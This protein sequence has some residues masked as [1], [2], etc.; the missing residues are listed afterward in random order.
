MRQIME[1]T[2]RSRGEVL[3]ME[4]NPDYWPS[5]R[6]GEETRNSILSLLDNPLF[7][8][9]IAAKVHRSVR[10][11]RRQITRLSSEGLVK[12]LPSGQIVKLCV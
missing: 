8:E 2:E 9:E 12:R 4:F 6:M 5:H 1:V 3:A 11:V 10:Q 7:P